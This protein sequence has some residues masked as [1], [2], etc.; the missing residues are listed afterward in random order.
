M[1]FADRIG[2]KVIR[3]V[4]KAQIGSFKSRLKHLGENV[5]LHGWIEISDPQNVEIKKGASLHDIFIQGTGGV[6]IGR[7]VHFGP[8]VS[9]YSSNHNFDNA[10]AIPY[11]DKIILKPVVI[12]DF[13]WVGA[14][15]CIVPGVRLGEGS[16][17]AMG[18][19]V[20]KDIPP[21]AIVGGNP[22]TIIRYRDREEFDRL[23][24]AGKFH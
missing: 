16:V 1:G 11:D 12:E 24:K 21:M 13:V 7:Y 3:F 15:V 5:G 10:E 17:I 19:V 14:H 6:S 23:K 18:S 4:Q 9:I 8:H 20:T 22:A 2:K